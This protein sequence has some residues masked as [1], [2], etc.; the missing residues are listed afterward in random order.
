MAHGRLR[1]ASAHSRWHMG[2]HAQL[3]TADAACRPAVHRRSVASIAPTH[4]GR[5]PSPGLRP[6]AS[7]PQGE[8]SPAWSVYARQR[9]V[10]A[11]PRRQHTATAMCAPGLMRDFGSRLAFAEN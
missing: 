7:I 8:A 11:V 1:P 2:C 6:H 3:F 9:S 10:A 4:T 5:P